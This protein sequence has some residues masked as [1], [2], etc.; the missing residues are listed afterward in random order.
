MNKFIFSKKSLSVT[1]CLLL[2]ASYGILPVSAQNPSN[3]GASLPIQLD[4]KE[5]DAINRQPIAKS[6]GAKD[7]VQG[8]EQRRLS[9]ELKQENGTHIREYREGNKPVDIEVESRFGTHYHM[10]DPTNQT[11]TIRDQSIERVPAV[12][13]SF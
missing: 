6:I 9:Y 12:R 10:S 4:Q 11:P 8:T 3:S 5:L 13:M 7:S 2:S 1:T